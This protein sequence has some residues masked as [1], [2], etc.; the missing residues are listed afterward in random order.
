MQSDLSIASDRRADEPTAWLRSRTSAG[1]LESRGPPTNTGFARASSTATASR[2]GSRHRLKRSQ[3]RSGTALA[4]RC[5]LGARSLPMQSTA[6]VSMKNSPPGCRR[7]LSSSGNKKTSASSMPFWQT[8]ARLSFR[9]R[10]NLELLGSDRAPG[11]R[12]LSRTRSS[13]RKEA[14][15]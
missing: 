3:R 5:D 4:E 14:S 9:T 8:R 7:T 1:L 10:A 13:G 11:Q 15:A 12:A 2:R 6:R